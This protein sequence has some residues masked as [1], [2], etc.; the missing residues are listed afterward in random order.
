MH[1]RYDNKKS[2]TYQ[3]NGTDFD[4]VYGSGEVSG[5]WSFDTVTLAGTKISKVQFGQATVLKGLGF[6]AGRFD[7][8]LGM[9]WTAISIDGI[10]PVF[11]AGWNQGLWQDNSFA[12][13]LTST[14]NQGGSALILGGVDPQY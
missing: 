6:I 2:S 11:V 9:G 1:N 10:T 12:F 5:F 8:I 3:K 4:I 14:P 7:G 13:F